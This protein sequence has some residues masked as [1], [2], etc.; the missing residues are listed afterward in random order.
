VVHRWEPTTIEILQ[1][2]CQLSWMNSMGFS[3]RLIDS[4]MRDDMPDISTV[5]TM[6]ESYGPDETKKRLGSFLFG[7][8]DDRR[9]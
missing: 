8:V 2:R 4:I 9:K 3:D 5:R 1:R 7:E 6:V